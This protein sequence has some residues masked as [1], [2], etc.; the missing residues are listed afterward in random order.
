MS[1]SDLEDFEDF[2]RCLD[3]GC[4]YESG[5]ACACYGVPDGYDLNP[6]AEMPTKQD[7]ASA[8]RR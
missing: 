2:D 5:T 1:E 6:E 7:S 8:V 3:C 4:L